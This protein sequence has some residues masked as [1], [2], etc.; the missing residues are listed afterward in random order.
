MMDALIIGYQKTDTAFAIEAAND[1][2][3]IALQNFHQRCFAST[4]AIK[5][6]NPCQN[7]VTMQ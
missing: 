4:A 7:A 6:G 5:A 3:G 2:F 1:L